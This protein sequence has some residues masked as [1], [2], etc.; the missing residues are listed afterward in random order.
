[1]SAARKPRPGDKLDTAPTRVR[2]YYST[3]YGRFR[4][5][6]TILDGGLAMPALPFWFAREAATRA[7]ENIPKL[8]RLRGQA[9]REEA[10]RWIAKAAVEQRDAASDLGSWVHDYAEAKV[11]GTP[12]PRPNNEQ[13]PFV[14][15]VDR[16]LLDHTPEFEATEMTVANPHDEWAGT[17]DAWLRLPRTRYGSAMLLGDYKTS[18]RARE[19]TA[20]QCA[21]YQRA[22]VGWLKDGTEVTPPPV[23]AAVLI[24]IRPDLYPDTGY[25]LIPLDTADPVYQQFLRIRDID[26]EWTRGLAK[27]A[28]GDPL[29]LINPEAEVA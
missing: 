28:L 20:L 25:A 8:A 6:T 15:A 26:K 11:L 27:N 9:A 18:R 7:V 19:K 21:A 10:A 22:T 14:R 16:F 3:P 24:H 29:E 4:S 5:V 2:G 17:G 23:E 12:F 1:M 13:L